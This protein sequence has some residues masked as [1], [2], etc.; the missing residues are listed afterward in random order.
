MCHLMMTCEVILF[1]YK[2][3]T[4]TAEVVPTAIKA[5]LHVIF[6]NFVITK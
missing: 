4:V 3:N 2:E 6:K 5:N 1:H